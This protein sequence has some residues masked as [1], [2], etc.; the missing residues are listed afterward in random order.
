MTDE[1]ESLTCEHCS[2]EYPADP[3]T[4]ALQEAGDW[5]AEYCPD[6]RPLHFVCAD[7]GDIPHRHQEHDHHPGCCEGC[8]DT[9]EEEAK[10]EVLEAA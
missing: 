5:R 7:C 2:E 9:R 10:T 6:C 3:E 1:P 4:V 8:G